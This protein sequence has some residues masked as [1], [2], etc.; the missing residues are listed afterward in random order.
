M[1]ARRFDSVTT[2]SYGWAT[3]CRCRDGPCGLSLGSAGCSRE[4]Y[5]C[6]ADKDASKLV[7]EKS[8]DPRWVMPPGFTVNQ[9]PRSRYYDPCDQVFPPMPP[10]DPASDRLIV[11]LDGM[12]GFRHWH[13]HGDRQQLDN[14]DWQAR[15]PNASR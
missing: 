14:P 7:A 4:H 12:K 6:Q 11:C 5:Y 2:G 9:D 1:L 13:D 15:L 8:C 10:D 3:A